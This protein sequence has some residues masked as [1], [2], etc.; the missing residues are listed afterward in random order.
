MCVM[1]VI[2]AIAPSIEL[3]W[4]M[5]W[6]QTIGNFD[7]TMLTEGTLSV[8]VFIG[9]TFFLTLLMLNMIIANMGDSYARVK[10]SEKAEIMMEQA[11]MITTMECLYPWAHVYSK[12]MHLLEPTRA[13]KDNEAWEGIGGALNKLHQDLETKVGKME[14]QIEK[15]EAQLGEIHQ[16][17]LTNLPNIS[18]KDPEDN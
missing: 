14:V 4:R 15:V 3:A 11:R 13:R 2:L 7:V 12:Y 1:A 17:L 5:A 16:L 9:S 6:R 10:Q 18:Q 8:L